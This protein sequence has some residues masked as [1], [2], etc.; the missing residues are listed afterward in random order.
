MVMGALI[1]KDQALKDR[2][3]FA[4]KSFGGCPGAFDCYMALRGIKTLEARMLVVCK[5]AY[6]IA[7]FLEQHELVEKIYYPGL[8]SHP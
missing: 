6:S 7:K 4:A 5:N 2:L 1:V 8:D 3:F